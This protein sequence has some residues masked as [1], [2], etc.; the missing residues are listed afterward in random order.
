MITS[1]CVVKA[2]GDREVLDNV[3]AEMALQVF[4]KM[5]WDAELAAAQAEGEA[6]RVTYIPEFGLVDDAERM[7]II[8]PVDSNTMTVCLQCPDRP[9]GGA[10][11]PMKDVADLIRL[12]FAGDDDAIA[13]I[14]AK[15]TPAVEIPLRELSD[16][17]LQGT[18]AKPMRRLGEEETC[19]QVHL[20]D[21]LAASITAFSLPTSLDTIELADI[22]LSADKKHSHILFNYGDSGKELALVVQHDPEIGDSV[23]GHRFV[24]VAERCYA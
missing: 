21:Y 14:V 24:N 23:L 3:S 19:R 17:E 11:F 7:L 6:G 9:S 2:D 13:A 5:D 15:N 22:Y 4:A 16:A 18:I 1:L 8:S 12:F 10:D 20:R